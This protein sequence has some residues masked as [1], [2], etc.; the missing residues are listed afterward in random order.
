MCAHAVCGRSF[1]WGFVSWILLRSPV[2]S[3]ACLAGPKANWNYPTT[4]ANAHWP[5]Y[6]TCSPY[7]RR[8]FMTFIGHSME[9]SSCTRSWK[10]H[11]PLESFFSVL[12]I[13]LG[14]ECIH[15]GEKC[16]FFLSI[17][18][19][20]S[21][22][23]ESAVNMFVPPSRCCKHL[24]TT[25]KT[26]EWEQWPVATKQRNVWQRWNCITPSMW[27]FVKELVRVML[28]AGQGTRGATGGSTTMPSGM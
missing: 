11:C 5:M 10:M 26:Y 14:D 16:F 4:V 18:H 24:E 12:S 21:L 23:I 8:S 3:R 17:V 9:M 25:R 6:G 7:L 20:R 1:Y 28:S 13:H 2:S 19:W 27:H 22:K 15:L